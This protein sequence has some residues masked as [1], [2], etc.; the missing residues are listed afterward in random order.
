MDEPRYGLAK[1]RRVVESTPWGIATVYRKDGSTSYPTFPST[2]VH[3]MCIIDSGYSLGHPD[4]PT[5]AQG[6]DP[7]QDQP[8]DNYYFGTDTCGH[9]THVAGTIAAIGNNNE[10][11][12]GVWPGAPGLQI[13]KVFDNSNCDRDCNCWMY[14][15]TLVAAMQRCAASGAKI[16]SSE[17]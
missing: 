2:P 17:I 3:P 10:G 9:G 13:I 16:I 8:G 11:V 6:A 14:S 15:S 5:D 12:V 7:N 1:G 4:L